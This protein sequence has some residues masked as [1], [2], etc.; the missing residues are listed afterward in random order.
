MK[1]IIF[2]ALAFAASLTMMGEGYQVNTLS[3]KQEGMGHTGVAQKLGAESMIFNPAG[4]AFMNKTLDLS[5]SVSPIFSTATAT[6]ENGSKY[7]TSNDVSTPFQISGAFTIF[8]NLK[9]GVTINTPYGSGI[10]WTDNWP[11]ATFSQ[12]TKLQVFNIQPTVAY[13]ILPNLSVGAGLMI[14]W[15]S[16]D[17]NKGLLSASSINAIIPGVVQ[18]QIYQQLVGQYGA[19]N[20]NQDLV[21]SVYETKGQAIVNSML[22]DEEITPASVNLKGKAEV[23][24]GFSVG[25]MWDINDKITIGASYKSKMD[26]KVKAGDAKVSYNIPNETVAGV[27]KSKLNLLNNTNFAAQ[28]PAVAQL[29]FGVCYKP[30]KQLTL[31]FDAQMS[32]WSAYDELAIDFVGLDAPFDQKLTKK[33][34]DAWAFRL[35]A[36]YNLTKRLDLRAG[37]IVDTTPVNENYF[38]PETPGMTRYEPTVGLSFRPLENLSVDFAFTYIAGDSRKG[39]IESTDFL[40]GQ[41]NKFTAEY[42]LEAFIPAIGLSYSF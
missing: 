5:A 11:G 33:Y 25:A 4:M 6:L 38:N 7:E 18:Q 17:L 2:S 12:S 27:V 14:A 40:T 39:S 23:A 31:A 1:K 24:V 36:Q 29:T 16:V 8:D 42:D 34:S 19:E 30:I 35:G 9:A 37:F 28:L 22:L 3:V 10:D 41:T 13:K 15:G 20:V 26:M 32:S 21:N